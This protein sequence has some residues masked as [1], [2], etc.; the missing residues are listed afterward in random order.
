[1]QDHHPRLPTILADSDS[2]AH[3]HS[4]IYR[5]AATPS[6]QRRLLLTI[7][8]T[9][10]ILALEIV[11]GILANSLALL[12][13]AGHVFTDLAALIL[14]LLALRLA[15]RP[16]NSR[17]TFGFHRFEI[18][19]ALVNGVTLVLISL[20]IFVEA[21]RRLR[22]P[23]PVLGLEVFV[24]AAVGLLG[25]GI[26]VFLLR[27]AGDNMN[28]RGAMLHL[29]GDAVSSVGVILSGVVI[30]LTGWWVIDPIVSIGIGLVIILGAIRLID[31]SVDVLLEGTPRHI[32]L[33]KVTASI[34]AVPGVCSVHDVHI[35]CVTPQLCTMSGHVVLGEDDQ[36]RAAAILAEINHILDHTYGLS[37]TTIQLESEHCGK[38]DLEW[39]AV[40]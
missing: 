16:A 11:G 19:S 20:F 33:D 4:H 24:I 7:A 8:V 36:G 1:V 40:K 37:H 27:D 28:L 30:M 25:N 32:D 3:E 21:Y 13:D 5:G 34:E 12:S 10:G 18:L 9:V 35:W 17:K 6:T 38:N 22:N 2:H 15:A 14:S 23:Q 26:G 39:L 29:I 31:E